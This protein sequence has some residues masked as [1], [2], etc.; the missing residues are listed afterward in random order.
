MNS[1]QTYEQ[2]FIE[3]NC[4]FCADVD[5]GK[6]VLDRLAGRGYFPHCNSGTVIAYQRQLNIVYG[7]G[8]Y[9]KEGDCP[10]FKRDE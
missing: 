10:K 8:H 5:E 7:I 4:Q 6:L 2:L 1:G 3:R 9:T